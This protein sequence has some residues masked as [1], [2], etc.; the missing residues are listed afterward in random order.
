MRTL[1]SLILI[2]GTAVLA[3]SAA[4]QS[5]HQ[6]NPATGAEEVALEN[7]LIR[8]KVAIAEG[9]FGNNGPSGDHE[10]TLAQNTGAPGLGGTGQRVWTN[11]QSVAFAL[12]RSGD[13]IRFTVGNQILTQTFLDAS[14]I[15]SF[16][17]RTFSG[18]AGAAVSITN[19]AFQGEDFI[20]KSVSSNGA[21]DRNILFIK[22]LD[23]SGDSW[24]LEGIMNFSWDPSNLPLNSNLAFQIKAVEAVPE[25]ATMLGLGIGAALVGLRRRRQSRKS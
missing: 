5:F 10:L 11:G 17:I 14:K 18:R 19:L 25:P 24:E 7:S 21:G 22:G 8:N 3:S 9:R 12:D 4:A 20:G 13:T 23:T 16:Y 1:Q 15:D 6:F 2:G